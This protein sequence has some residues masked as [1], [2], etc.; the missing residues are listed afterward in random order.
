MSLLLLLQS[1]A[2]GTTVAVGQALE[3]DLAQPVAVNPKRRLVGLTVEADV[4][5]AV[6]RAKVKAVGINAETDLAQ[7]VARIKTR[8]VGQ[9]LETDL[10]QL[11]RC[12]LY[13]SPSPRDS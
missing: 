1:A 4:A 6:A 5:Q 2:T 3:T 11:V 7:P 13:T 10:A 8:T 9:A 12:L